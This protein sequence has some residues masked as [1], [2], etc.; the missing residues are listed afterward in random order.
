MS[1]NSL[2][3]RLMF[4]VG[5]L[6]V[7]AVCAVAFSARHLTHV[8]FGKYQQYEQTRI[9]AQRTVSRLA[10]RC[11]TTEATRW[12]VAE[13]AQDQALIIV[14]ADGRLITMSGPGVAAAN[15]RQVQIHLEKGVLRIAGLQQEAGL[16]R[17]MILQVPASESS[18]VVRT[19]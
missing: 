19:N 1:F 11:C 13:L 7:A 14:A 17:K 9:S 8:E 3:T 12:A 16:P 6:A 2:E 4:A 15:L 5:T 10:G 18:P